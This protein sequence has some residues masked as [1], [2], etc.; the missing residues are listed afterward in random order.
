[1][2]YVNFVIVLS[3]FV[4]LL[5]SIR[6][7]RIGYLNLCHF[8]AVCVVVT[9]GICTAAIED[10]GSAWKTGLQNIQCL[11]RNYHCRLLQYDC[12]LLV[13]FRRSFLAYTQFHY[14][15]MQHRFFSRLICGTAWRT[16]CTYVFLEPYLALCLP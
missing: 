10:G 5:C 3:D 11:R 1:M 9:Y 13:S 6:A 8:V 16:Y 12:Q 7:L 15:M 14:F 2:Y 4:T